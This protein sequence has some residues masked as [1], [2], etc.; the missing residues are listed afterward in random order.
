M[1]CKCMGHWP[2]QS[3]KPY[4]GRETAEV[5]LMPEPTAALPFGWEVSPSRLAFS[6]MELVVQ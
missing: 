3:S 2:G 4:L 5:V 1:L 6:D